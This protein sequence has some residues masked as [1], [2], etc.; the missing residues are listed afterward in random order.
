MI[1]EQP[2][3]LSDTQYIM[4]FQ[5]TMPHHSEILPRTHISQVRYLEAVDDH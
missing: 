5:L 3:S 1:L 4:P 2:V